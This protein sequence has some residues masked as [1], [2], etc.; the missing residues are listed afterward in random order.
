MTAVHSLLVTFVAAFGASL[1]FTAIVKSLATLLGILDRPDGQRKLHDRPVPLWGGVGVYLAMLVGLVVARGGRFGVG[2]SLDELAWVVAAAAGVVCVIGCIDDAFRLGPRVKLLLQTLSVLPVVL[3]GYSVEQ[4]IVLGW[5]IEFGWLGIPVT[6]LWLVGCINALNLLDGMDGLA[7]LVG[8]F[9][10]A[11]MGVIATYLGN[12]YVA[13]V[14][15][16][17]AAALAGFFAHNRPPAS[18]FLGDSGS[19]VIGM[20]V[21]I[22]GIQSTLKTSATLSI[23]APLV[24]MTLPAFDTVLA[25]I[26]RRLTGRP[27]DAADRQHIHHRLLD[28]GMAPWWVLAVLGAFCLATGVAATVATI[29]RLEILAWCT[30]GVVIVAAVRFR[31]FGHYELILLVDAA[32]RLLASLAARLSAQDAVF[33]PGRRLQRLAPAEAWVLL[34]EQLRP[35]NPCQLQLQVAEADEIRWQKVW[36]SPRVPARRPTWWVGVTSGPAA[37]SVCQLRVEG[38]DPWALDPLSAFRLVRLLQLFADHF[39]TQVPA[40]RPETQRRAA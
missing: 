16:A 1:A 21:G 29:L 18:I 10:A 40:A 38:A 27:F 34:I 24:V 6:V 26:R 8:I 36:V 15:V 12:S 25:V 31:L 2:P 17:L 20:V 23:T 35:W 19:M 22:L 37:P 39:A 3:A 9:T 33:G 4:I 5:T 11:T 28:R 14:A 30:A 7:S 32:A 13:V